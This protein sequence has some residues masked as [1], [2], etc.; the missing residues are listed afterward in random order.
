MANASSFVVALASYLASVARETV[1]ALSLSDR[2][3]RIRYKTNIFM[4]AIAEIQ[5]VIIS[6]LAM[7][8][9]AFLPGFIFRNFPVLDRLFW[10]CITLNSFLVSYL[11][12]TM[13]WLA[14]IHF[15]VWLITSPWDVYK[16]PSPSK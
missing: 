9:I 14:L 15:R 12:V 1:K 5:L 11:L 6:V 3:G 10:D 13:F 7:C 4:M 2:D 8:K 16:P